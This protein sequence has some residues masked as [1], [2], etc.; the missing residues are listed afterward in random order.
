M[1]FDYLRLGMFISKIKHKDKK[2]QT[3]HYYV[4]LSV[5]LSFFYV[6]VAT[7]LTMSQNI[8]WSGY[9]ANRLTVVFVFFFLGFCFISKIHLYRIISLSH[10]FA[11][12]L[13]SWTSLYYMY[14]FSIMCSIMWS[15]YFSIVFIFMN[16][17]CIYRHYC[18]ARWNNKWT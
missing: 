2:M 9:Q 10:V 11:G 7:S 15:I 6:L 4:P 1:I 3:I 13:D 5:F 17:C 14:F 12:Y 16:S 18:N 8:C